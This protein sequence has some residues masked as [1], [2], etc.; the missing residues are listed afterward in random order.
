[1]GRPR[2]T[3][4]AKLSEALTALHAVLGAE[5]GVIRGKQLKPATRRL[6]VGKGFLREILKGWYFVSDPTADQGDTTPF[7]AN[8]WEYLAAYLNERFA[9]QYCLTPEHSLLRHAQNTVVPKQVSVMLAVNQTQLQPLAFAYSLMLYP[10]MSSFPPSQHIRTLHGL[11]CVSPE[12]ALVQLTPSAF[13]RHAAEVQMVL[14]SLQDPSAVAMLVTQNASGVGRVVAA[15]RSIHRQAFADEIERNIAGLGV[16]VPA[17]TDPFQG[18]P[19]YQLGALE[20]SPLYAR[21]QLLWAQHRATVLQERP[22]LAEAPRVLEAYLAEVEALKVQD[23][24]HS[25]SIERYRV[26]PELIKKVAEGLWSP[27][28][29]SQDKQQI[30]AMAARGYLA[31]F[32]LVKEAAGVA[33]IE[34]PTIPG[35]AAAL[36]KDHHQAWFQS[37]FGPSVT[38]GLLQTEDLVGYR[39]H[40]V[41]L[42][43]SLHSPPHSDYVRDGM[44]ALRECFERE[45]D[46][47]VRAVLGHWL[48]GFIHPYMDGNG[49][50][51]RFLMNLMLASGGYPW[52]VI[53][54]ETRDA[55]M[56]ALERAS[57]ENDLQPFA[58]FVANSLRQQGAPVGA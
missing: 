27:T 37:L 51:A 49:R 56:A 6:L 3:E 26:T 11:R 21:I 10:A 7:F 24:Y 1:M 38:A 19:T 58:R 25:L 36:F 52:T 55:Y 39:R 53:R 43:G 48:F 8:F 2:I 16:T 22:Q 46:A 33:F 14:S 23:A 32:R 20:K 30:D 28:T 15:A 42:R 31:A 17:S 35:R 34:E 45:P 9:A 47:F 44:M 54:V 41:F 50:M 5:R 18:R 13:A 57:V 40:M 29:D 4:Q 12:Y